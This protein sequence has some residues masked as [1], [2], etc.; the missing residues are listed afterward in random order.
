MLFL[1]EPRSA[2][3]AAAGAAAEGVFDRKWIERVGIV[4]AYPQESVRTIQSD[5]KLLQLTCAMDQIIR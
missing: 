2:S 3:V 1:G 5:R 4:V